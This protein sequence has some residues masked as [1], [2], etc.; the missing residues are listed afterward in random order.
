MGVIGCGWGLEFMDSLE[1]VEVGK[2]TDKWV[3]R[4]N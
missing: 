3:S 1:T 2:E 4:S